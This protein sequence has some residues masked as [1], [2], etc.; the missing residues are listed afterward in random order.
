M[1]EQ[2]ANLGHPVENDASTMVRA[3]SSFAPAAHEKKSVSLLIK[4][5]I[6]PLIDPVGV[7]HNGAQP[8]S[9]VDL[10]A[11]RTTFIQPLA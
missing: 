8:R 2:W 5:R 11:S 3:T 1:G 10:Q 4:N 6:F 7:G 9:P